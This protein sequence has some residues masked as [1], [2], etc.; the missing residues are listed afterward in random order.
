MIFK[1]NR[2]HQPCEL[3]RRLWN[4]SPV[5]LKAGEGLWTPLN[6][7]RPGAH[8]WL[9]G[10]TVSIVWSPHSGKTVSKQTVRRRGHLKWEPE[11]VSGH[12]KCVSLPCYLED[13]FYPRISS[14]LGLLAKIKCSMGASQVAWVVKNLPASAGDARDA[15][16]IPGWGKYFGGGHGNPLQCSCLRNPMDREA[17]RA[18][19]SRVAK[20]RTW[21]S[22]AHT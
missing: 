13:L 12:S 7:T 18:I 14:L 1:K 20:S 16:L 17:W 8:L 5:L 10:N 2:K 6:P 9:A 15:G 3:G 11:N 21:L 19:V 4:Q 22:T